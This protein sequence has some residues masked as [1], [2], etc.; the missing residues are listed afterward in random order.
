MEEGKRQALIQMARESDYYSRGIFEPNTARGQTRL[1]MM[2]MGPLRPG[3][4]RRDKR[5][6]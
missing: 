3:K 1:Q 4:T 6:G 2:N 5:R